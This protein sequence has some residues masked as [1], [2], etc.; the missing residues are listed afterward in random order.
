MS[1]G[2]ALHGPDKALVQN[3]S[4][5][6]SSL[7]TIRKGELVHHPPAAQVLSA[8]QELIKIRGVGKQW[9]CM[10]YDESSGCTIYANRPEACRALKCWDTQAIEALI[11]HDT[12][13]RIDLVES[14]DP[15]YHAIMEHE[16]LFPCPDL[17]SILKHG[18][19]SGPQEL[20]EM[21]N[22]EL[23]Y[24]TRMV[25]AQRLTLHQELFYFGRPLFQLLISVGGEVRQVGNTLHV[26]W[27]QRQG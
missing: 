11:E 5:P 10:Y 1:G 17:E 25:G 2:P 24:R 3:G 12:L 22:R 15:L 6:L 9:T 23:A 26:G 14:D 8:R 20:E 16:S 21:V 19:V 27:P 4:I 13:S 7:I 18:A